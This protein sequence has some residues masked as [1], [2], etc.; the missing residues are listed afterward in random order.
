MRER[1]SPAII[2]IVFYSM[3]LLDTA[4]AILTITSEVKARLLAVFYGTAEAV[5][6]T[7]DTDGSSFPPQRTSTFAGGPGFARITHPLR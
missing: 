5:P 2:L 6:L 7:K 1:N 4:S 3:V